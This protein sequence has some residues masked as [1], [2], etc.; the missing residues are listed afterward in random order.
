MPRPLEC[1]LT[2]ITVLVRGRAKDYRNALSAAHSEWERFENDAAREVQRRLVL[3]GFLRGEDSMSWTAK[4]ETCADGVLNVH[5]TAQ[6][7][8]GKEAIKEVEKLMDK[9]GE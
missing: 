8:P 2:E 7:H 9:K 1:S 4:P 3:T 6:W 5:I